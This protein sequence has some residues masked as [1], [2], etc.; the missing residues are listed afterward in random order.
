MLIK[1]NFINPNSFDVNYINYSDTQISK[2]FDNYS[3]LFFSD[4][5]YGAFLKEERLNKFYNE[6]EDLQ[7]DVIIF[8]GDLFDTNY[9]I[10]E[11]DITILTNKLKNM[12]A[13]NGKFAIL[14]D[15]DLEE[16]HLEIVK[17]ILYNADFEILDNKLI[18]LHNK[19]TSFINLYGF[20]YSDEISDISSYYSSD[21]TSNFTISVIHGALLA[22]SIV[23]GYS[24]LTLS[25]HSHHA[26]INLVKPYKE[27]KMT[28]NHTTGLQTNTNTSLYVTTGVGTTNADARL[29]SNPEVLFIR[30]KVK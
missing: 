13:K 27:Y 10:T 9:A 25:G 24:N 20:T 8:G 7:P 4:L 18:Q 21:D 23:E 30:L 15:F 22:D 16:E 5:E 14:G 19:T 17:T 2:D 12:S 3:I 1:S 28:G 26:Q 11:T 29:L 6:I